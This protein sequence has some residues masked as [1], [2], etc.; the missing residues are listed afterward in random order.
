MQ[1]PIDVLK[2]AVR[3]KSILLFIA[4]QAALGAAQPAMESTGANPLWINA[5][6]DIVAVIILRII[7]KSSLADKGSG[8]EKVME[9]FEKA[10]SLLM[11]PMYRQLLV[12]ML[13]QK[14]INIEVNNP[15]YA[16]E[17]V[18]KIGEK[19]FRKLKDG[20]FVPI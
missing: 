18:Y 19:N 10:D 13:K 16:D 14:G 4:L 20:S 2:G 1:R 3:S 12:P 9:I 15:A 11:N 5:T 6:I 17:K 7:T 8:F